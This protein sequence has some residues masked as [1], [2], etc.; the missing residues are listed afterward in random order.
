MTYPQESSDSDSAC[1]AAARR[2]PVDILCPSRAE[3][4]FAASARGGTPWLTVSSF[5]SSAR[6]NYQVIKLK[7]GV[8]IF[9][10]VCAN[11]H[12]RVRM[13]V[14]LHVHVYVWINERGENRKHSF[15]DYRS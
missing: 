9:M 13:C 4:P 5:D 2:A 3:F 10:R 14:H 1:R 7:N 6:K 12:V 15:D 8:K 11:V